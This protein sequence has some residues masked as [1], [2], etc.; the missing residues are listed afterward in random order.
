MA[1]VRQLL[2]VAACVVVAV[3][4]LLDGRWPVVIALAAVLAVHAWAARRVSRW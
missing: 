3:L 4:A 2:F 1:P